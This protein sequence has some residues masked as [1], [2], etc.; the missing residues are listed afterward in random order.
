M[1]YEGPLLVHKP[2][3]DSTKATLSIDASR[4]RAE[5]I[6][7]NL[8]GKFC[9]HLGFN[10]Y[11]GMDA[12]ILRNPTFGKW[13]FGSGENMINGGVQVEIDPQKIAQ[14]AERWTKGLAL[15]EPARLLESYKDSIAFHWSRLGE[16][17][18][19]RYSPDTGPHGG[20]A[21]RIEILKAP[22]ATQEHGIAQYLH[23]PV[24]RTRK[25]QFRVVA[26]A[27]ENVDVSMTLGD[28]TSLKPLA[29]TKLSLCEDWQT[30]SGELQIAG[31]ETFTA[32]TMFR[33]TLTAT[34]SANIVLGRVVLLPDDHINGADP[35]VIA[36][37]KDSKLP[38][39]RW[40]GGN[41]V[42]GYRWRDGVGPVDQRPTRPNPAWDGLEY[43]F[44]GTDEF[45]A[46]CKVVGCQPLIC[47]NAGDGTPEEAAAWVEYCN[48]A[49]TTPMGR[50][51][52][53]NG[54]PEPYGIK[55]WEVGNEL[56][57]QWQVNWTYSGG[58]SDRYKRFSAAMLK[59]DPSIQL[60]GCGLV[61]DP[62][63]EWNQRLIDDCKSSLRSIT[64]HILNGC[65]VTAET[66]PAEL[67]HA[68]MGHSVQIGREY[69][70]LRRR[71][72]DGGIQNPRMAITECQ[73]FA[74]FSGEEK[75]DG[76]LSRKTLFNPATISEAV[77]MT[78]L[79]NECVRLGDFVEF[80][81]HSATVNHGGGLRK[82]RER[83]YA[84]PVHY[85]HAMSAPLFGATPV[86][87]ELS[88]GVY[89]TK[90]K[91]SFIEPLE[92]VPNVDALAALSRDGKE[93]IVMLAH[94]SATAGAIQLSLGV[95]NFNAAAEAEVV[96]LA[97]EVPYGANTETEPERI[98]PKVSGVRVQSGEKLSLTLP[99]YSVTRLILKRA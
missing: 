74:H 80:F 60:L 40:P 9:E 11:H 38:L 44:Y 15:P 23:L 12:Q 68:Y 8:Y 62:N 67:Y 78:T 63:G 3:A 88:S 65:N 32:T 76:K 29:Q 17:S 10:I 2:H 33:L 34:T 7:P 89:S 16:K 28:G 50:L 85:A 52:A 47:V 84:N 70:Q 79:V 19:V 49:A 56:S 81:T 83:V 71:M 96:T 75:A 97:D 64:A 26:R 69:A 13:N 66:D 61:G 53:E 45:M 37:L 43:N 73:L 90:T 59:A 55:L 5:P 6:N 48:G 35:D 14:Y 1:S 92:N 91:F 30:F 18:D 42:S 41:F 82:Q 72:V 27:A 58:N 54:H 51:R 98:K 77:Y 25:F 94:R 57:G 99:P 31:S 4:K 24:H 20:R 36:M 21:Q 46:Y 86:A 22:T 87:V 93:L 95:K 39:L